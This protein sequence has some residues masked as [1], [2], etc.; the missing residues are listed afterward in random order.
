MISVKSP[1]GNLDGIWCKS[2]CMDD[3]PSYTYEQYTLQYSSIYSSWV[4]HDSN[5]VLAYSLNSFGLHPLS[6]NC[7]EWIFIGYNT[8]DPHF[9][10]R[11]QS[12]TSETPYEME[13]LGYDYFT[14]N[15]L[16]SPIWY[17]D[18]STNQIEHSGAK[19]RLK[20]TLNKKNK[21]KVSEYVYGKRFCW[22]C[23]QSFSA[24]NFVS[25]HLRKFHAISNYIHN[26]DDICS[27]IIHSDT[28]LKQ[29]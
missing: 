21:K 15:H 22:A 13:D 12:N 6:I 27:F 19:E 2:K 4:I 9:S 23:F 7:G 14:R 26:I 17:I 24:N 11:I 10:F 28:L 1:N 5:I 20:T 29:E 18:P 3:R 16:T 8:P 25:Q